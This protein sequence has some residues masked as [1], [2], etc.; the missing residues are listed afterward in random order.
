M[1]KIT[2]KLVKRGFSDL[3]KSNK[4][5]AFSVITRERSQTTSVPFEY[6]K[7]TQNSMEVSQQISDVQ[8]SKKFLKKSKI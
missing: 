1:N 6:F 2:S 8:T 7:L 5:R 4:I 3:F